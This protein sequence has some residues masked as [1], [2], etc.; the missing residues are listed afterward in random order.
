MGYFSKLRAGPSAGGPELDRVQSI[1]THDNE[2]TGA[3]VSDATPVNTGLS[4]NIKSVP[5]EDSDNDDELV[6]KDMQIGV[7][8]IE[9]LAQVWPK[10]ALYFTYAW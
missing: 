4:G 8:K 2:K 3:A 7:Q 5:A 9:G 1:P 10:W 6:H